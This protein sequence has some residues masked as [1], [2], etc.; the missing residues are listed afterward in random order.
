MKL[1][2]FALNS[3]HRARFVMTQE[4][5]HVFPQYLAQ[6]GGHNKRG[7][8]TQSQSLFR[9]HKFF[10]IALVQRGVLNFQP[11]GSVPFGI[12][13]GLTGRHTSRNT[14]LYPVF[15]ALVNSSPHLAHLILVDELLAG[16]PHNRQT[17]GRKRQHQVGTGG[18]VIVG[19][20][21]PAVGVTNNQ[22]DARRPDIDDRIQHGTTGLNDTAT[23]LLAS[24]QEA[25]GVFH[26][27]HRDV[28]DIAETVE[29]GNLVGGIDRNLT[30]CH[31]TVVGDKTDNITPQSTKGGNG[32][33]GPITLEFK[34][35]TVIADLLDHDGDIKG[36]VKAGG[37]VE[38]L[39]QQGVDLPGFT[40]QWVSRLTETGHDAVVIGEIG[41]QLQCGTQCIHFILDRHV[42]NPGLSVDL[43]SAQI[44]RSHILT[45]NRLDHSRSGQTEEGVLGLNQE[46]ALAGEVAATTGI[47][48]EHAHNGGDNPADFAQRRKGFGIAVQTTHPGRHKGTGRVVHTDQGDTLLAGHLEQQGQFAAVGGI[49]G[50]SPNGEIVTVDRHVATIDIEDAGHQRGA[51]QVLT[52]VLEKNI[53]FI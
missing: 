23:L 26:E 29:A 32:F 47:E 8:G 41:K 24:R 2:E 50:A 31:G 17:G 15:Y 40:I 49:D 16:R 11:V 20:I 25:G 6:V 19:G 38:S 52:P 22:Q 46:T 44:F 27:D 4:E 42:G 30:R 21:R 43:G 34:V 10:F 14:F 5:V 3:L 7:D 53:G 36:G 35:I 12:Y 39:L 18:V 28:V 51:V 33:T 1:M 13:L 9:V 48:S 45:Q 37:R